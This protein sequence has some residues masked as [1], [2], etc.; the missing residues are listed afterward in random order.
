MVFEIMIY[1]VPEGGLCNRMRTIASV[2]LLAVRVGQPMTINWWRTDDMNCSFHELFD[3]EQF[4][5]HVH[6]FNVTLWRAGFF[7]FKAYSTEFLM[8]YMGT[9]VLDPQES[10]SLVNKEESLRS[11]AANGNPRIRSYS[12]LLEDEHL[13]DCFKP[14]KRLQAVIDQ[15]LPRLQK[16]VGV[17]IRRSDNVK[18]SQYSPTIRFIELMHIELAHDFNTQFFVA[19]DSP[20]TF[21]ALKKEFGEAVFEHPKLSLDRSDPLA[22]R[23]ALVDL[24]CLASC[25]KLLGSY[26]S[27]FTDT[28]WEIRGIDHI[29]VHEQELDKS[30][31]LI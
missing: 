28:A 11:W 8:R 24:Y 26:W 13:F 23:D 31:Q 9:P 19:T 16:S 17:H 6:E 3:T 5:F 20:D 29:I 7:K 14:T 27:S 1:L 12:K 21:S 22:I 10:A 4:A 15:Y 18:S 2:G 25:R 30:D